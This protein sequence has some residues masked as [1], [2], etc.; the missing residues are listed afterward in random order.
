ML[1]VIIR[2]CQIGV[3]IIQKKKMRRQKKEK[4]Q[5]NKKNICKY[6]VTLR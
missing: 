5:Q 2:I 1:R 6:I 4:K 3:K